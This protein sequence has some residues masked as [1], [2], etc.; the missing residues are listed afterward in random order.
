[1][2][3]FR[4]TYGG[5]VAADRCEYF[6]GICISTRPVCA[7]RELWRT[8]QANMQAAAIMQPRRGVGSGAA[9]RGCCP[10]LAL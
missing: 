4:S 10:T 2:H 7:D 5:L 8:L 6:C 3:A 1:M 9:S